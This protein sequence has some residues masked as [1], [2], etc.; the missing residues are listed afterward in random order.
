MKL[1]FCVAAG[2]G[3]G[4]KKQ[5]DQQKKKKKEKKNVT[6]NPAGYIFIYFFVNGDCTRP[7]QLLQKSIKTHMQTVRMQ[8]KGPLTIIT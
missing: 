5:T 6:S 4:G 8:L 7:R 2:E 3:A 1:T